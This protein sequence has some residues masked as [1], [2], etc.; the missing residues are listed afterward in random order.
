MDRR[1]IVKEKIPANI[2]HILR[3]NLLSNGNGGSFPGDKE[4]GTCS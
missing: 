2:K 4:A 3:F 1:E